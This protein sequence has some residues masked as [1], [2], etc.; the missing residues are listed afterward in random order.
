MPLRTRAEIYGK[1]AAALL[2]EVSLYPGIR[3]GQ[4]SAFHPG[5]EGTVNNLLAHLKRQGRI[6]EA[7]DGDFT[8]MGSVPGLLTAAW[9]GRCGSCWISWTGWSSIRPGTSR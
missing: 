1:E 4:L 8:L 6:A 3:E 5:K 2:Q 9:C 7:E